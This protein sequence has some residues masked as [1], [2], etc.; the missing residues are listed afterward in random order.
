M[1][2]SLS[3]GHSDRRQ[4]DSAGDYGGTSGASS[5]GPELAREPYRR[6]CDRHLVGGMYRTCGMAL[7]SLFGELSSP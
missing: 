5:N 4:I 7:L 6:H 2:L 1:M 3:I